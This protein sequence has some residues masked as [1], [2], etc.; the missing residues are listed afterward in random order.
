MVLAVQSKLLG[1]ILGWH[2]G[3][4]SPKCLPNIVLLDECVFCSSTPFIHADCSAINTFNTIST[5]SCRFEMNVKGP[6]MITDQLI[7]MSEQS[8]ELF[9]VAE[10]W[11]YLIP[12]KTTLVFPLLEVR[13]GPRPTLLLWRADQSKLI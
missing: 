3:I 1:P 11:C 12:P 9:S 7:N 2:L 6:I 10:P 4:H 13:T 8:S 5:D